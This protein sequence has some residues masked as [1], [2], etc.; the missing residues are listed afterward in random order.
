[1]TGRRKYR[2]AGS[3][4]VTIRP[5]QKPEVT[6]GSSLGRMSVEKQFVGDLVASSRGEMLTAMTDIAGSAAYVAIERVSGV[7]Q[8]RRGSFVFQHSG[9]MAHAVQRLSI[10]VVPD[11]GVDKLAG[12]DGSFTINIVDGQHFYEFDYTLPAEAG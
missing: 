3:F 9:T 5:L 2:A 11:S 4:T 7:L 8:G 10:T 1:V 12:I 6:A